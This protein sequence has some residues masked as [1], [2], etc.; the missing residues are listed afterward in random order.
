MGL[1]PLA[2]SPQI[3]NPKT[4]MQTT[5]W[6]FD[7]YP[8][9]DRMVLW[10]I[11]PEGR[12]V[13]VEDEFPYRVYL[14]GP[15][16]RLRSL[17]RTL[18]G[19]GWVRRSYPSRG[20]DLWQ[21]EEI[22]V[23]ALEVRAYG[24]L[25]QLRAWLGAL[26]GDVACYNCDLDPAAYYLYT[27]KLWPC[28]WYGL[29]VRDGRLQGIFPREEAFALEFSVPPLATMTLSLTRDPLL[30]LGAGNGVAVGW[31][32]RTL[33]LEAPDAPGLVAEAARLITRLDPDLVLSDWGDEEIIPALRRWSRQYGVD[34]PLDREASPPARKFTGGRS[35]FSYGR[36]VYQG[37]AAPFCGRWHVDRRNSFYYRESGLQGLMQISRI[38]Q[39]PLQQA[40]RAS[41]GTLITSMQLARAV[42]D[43]ILIPWRKG[44]VETF[45]TAGE[46]LTIDKGGLVFMPPVGLHFQV[47]ELD[48]A[49]MYPTIMTIHNIS[50][51][52]VNCGCCV[53]G[54]G[55]KGTRPYPPPTPPPPI[56]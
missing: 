56:P 42:A 45:K 47:A 21:G 29:E 51:E 26:E 1:R 30:P 46:L 44:Q 34:L 23:L 24:L 3:P 4:A 28:A 49:S 33:E 52:T 37:P 19:R 10:F 17:A 15:P 11:T 7:L 35:Y 9:R 39:M 36:I 18:G 13:R 5:G 8:L 25:G 16:G 2:L 27:R 48:F 31:E 14:G 55:P 50:P 41:P 32:G 12:R 22:P 20:Q 54:E 40:A 53:V 43:G 6:L 38:G